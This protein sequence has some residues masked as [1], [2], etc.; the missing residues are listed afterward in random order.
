MSYFLRQNEILFSPPDNSPQRRIGGWR[1]LVGSENKG[2]KRDMWMAVAATE[3]DL[4]DA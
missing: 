2:E 1:W 4:P 3:D